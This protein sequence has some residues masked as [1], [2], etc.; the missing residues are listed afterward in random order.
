MALRHRL[1]RDALQREVRSHGLL[2]CRIGAEHDLVTA[3]HRGGS[4]VLGGHRLIG[5]ALALQGHLEAAEVVEH[6]H[7]PLGEGLDDVVLH[8]EEH[9]AAVGLRHGGTVV[10]AAG[11]LL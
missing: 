3:N 5:V 6:H 1:R 10:D 9:G 11:Q 7:L 8:A 2:E 4:E